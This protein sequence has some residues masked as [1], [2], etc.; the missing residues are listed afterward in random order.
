MALELHVLQCT[1]SGCSLES[2]TF[3]VVLV[4]SLAGASENDSV[5]SLAAASRDDTV[6]SG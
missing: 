4:Q 2:Y 6:V 5:V 1:V 3:Y